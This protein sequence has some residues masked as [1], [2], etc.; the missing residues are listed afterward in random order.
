MSFVSSDYDS[1]LLRVVLP[2]VGTAPLIGVEVEFYSPDH[3]DAL[4]VTVP[5][6]NFGSTVDVTISD[7][8]DG[9]EYIISLAVYN[10]GGKGTPSRPIKASTCKSKHHAGTDVIMHN[11]CS[12][13]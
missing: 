13:D 2:T 9:T 5:S 8:Q 1:V 7:L 11:A 10:Y 12:V 3:S 6:I 4:N